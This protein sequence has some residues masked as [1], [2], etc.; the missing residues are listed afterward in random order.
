MF[1]FSS[2][3][4]RLTSPKASNNNISKG[5]QSAPAFTQ[6]T[7]LSKHHSSWWIRGTRCPEQFSR[8]LLPAF[9]PSGQGWKIL[10]T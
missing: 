8:S 6:C 2:F 10:V 3:V 9:P 4:M 1:P 5:I 7:R